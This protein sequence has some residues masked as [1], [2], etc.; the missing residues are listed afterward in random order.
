MGSAGLPTSCLRAREWSSRRLDG[1]LSDFEGRL[2]D[3]HLASCPACREFAALTAMA[4]ERLRLTPPE[5]LDRPIRLPR[6]RPLLTPVRLGAAAAVAATAIGLTGALTALREQPDLRR[7]PAPPPA[8]GSVQRGEQ[9]LERDLRRDLLRPRS[10]VPR[11]E[12]FHRD[13][14]LQ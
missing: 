9:Q 8:A 6:R 12:N 11:P 2:L 14:V 3:G 13:I 1:E 7:T 5:T 10:A 4:T